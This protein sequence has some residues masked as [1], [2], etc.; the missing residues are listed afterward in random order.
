MTQEAVQGVPSLRS[1]IAL[2][3]FN[4][5]Y[6]FH[7]FGAPI[8]QVPA[9]E[10]KQLVLPVPVSQ[11]VTVPTLLALEC[12]SI[13]LYHIISSTGKTCPLTSQLHQTWL[14]CP[15]L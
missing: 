10:K 14:H 11:N 1:K 3:R 4:A 13:P 15:F 8:E 7:I 9:E 6:S 5:I 2:N 12:H